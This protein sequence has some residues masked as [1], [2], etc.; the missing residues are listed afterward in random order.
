MLL[1]WVVTFGIFLVDVNCV[2]EEFV[3]RG[4]DDLNKLALDQL[5]AERRANPDKDKN[6][7]ASEDSPLMQRAKEYAVNRGETPSEES[8]RIMVRA[9]ARNSLVFVLC[10]NM[11]LDMLL[12]LVL[13][14]ATP[15]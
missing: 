2:L 8:L 15:D 5:F 10:A 7:F 1:L 12:L 14:P 3:I 9:P 4:P 13:V 6:S 11:L